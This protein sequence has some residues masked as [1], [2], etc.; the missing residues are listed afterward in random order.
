MAASVARLVSLP[1]DQVLPRPVKKLFELTL[2]I[3][4]IAVAV[5]LVVWKLPYKQMERI[6][7]LLGLGMLA[8]ILAVWR[9]LP[10]W[11]HLVHRAPHPIVPVTE[12]H[13]TYW[14]F[15]IEQI[16]SVFALYP[17]F[18]FT[19]GWS[20]KHCHGRT[21]EVRHRRGRYDVDRHGRSDPGRPLPLSR[22][23]SALVGSVRP[24]RRPHPRAGGREGDRGQ[25]PTAT[26]S[27]LWV[28]STRPLW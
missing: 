23:I 3:P 21:R 9:L 28:V 20:R 13:P 24:A 12:D 26:I 19:S 18:C 10:D 6:Y 16:S 5:W 2:W 4:V 25:T 27:A 11:S 22:A 15:A 8:V 7:G 1:S 14:Y 17:M